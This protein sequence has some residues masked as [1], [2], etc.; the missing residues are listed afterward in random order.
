MSANP[1]N[2]ERLGFLIGLLRPAP[3]GWVEAASQLPRLRVVLDDLVERAQAD[4]AFRATLIADLEAA[5][6][7]EGIE[8]R[9]HLVRELQT[10]LS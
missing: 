6:A 8:P 7:R 4:A 3:Q 1:W 5:L 10:R 9:P 2:E